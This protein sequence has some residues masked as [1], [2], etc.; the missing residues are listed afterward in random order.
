MPPED[1]E[2]SPQGLAIGSPGPLGQVKALEAGLGH[3]RRPTLT[4]TQ[5]LARHGVFC[6]GT[7]ADA[8]RCLVPVQVAAGWLH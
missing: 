8:K 4:C 7:N 3:K 1:E 6:L 5:L 2:P